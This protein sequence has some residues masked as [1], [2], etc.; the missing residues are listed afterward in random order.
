MG[1]PAVVR[2][3]LGSSA[4]ARIDGAEAVA[5]F[6]TSA[7][8]IPNIPVGPS[9]CGRMWQ[10]KAHVP[11]FVQCTI[12]SHRSPGAM[13]SVSHFHGLS[14]SQPSWSD[15]LKALGVPTVWVPHS[16]AACSQHAPNEHLLAPV[17][18]EGLR[19]MT[20]LFWDLGAQGRPV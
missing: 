7:V 13:L 9:A 15:A 11:G 8:T 16:Y 12:V 5:G 1:P 14:S 6:T 19:M 10:W 2:V 17:V 3:R 4:E 20:G 18:R